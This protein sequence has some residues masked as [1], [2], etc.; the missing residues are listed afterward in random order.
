MTVRK[1]DLPQLKFLAFPMQNAFRPKSNLTLYAQSS[2]RDGISKVTFY[3]SYSDGIKRLIGD[4]ETA[5]NVPE[6]NQCD[7][8]YRKNWTLPSLEDEDQIK[9]IQVWVEAIDKING[10]TE[11]VA[12]G[13][14]KLSNN[15]QPTVSV[16]A[17]PST[18]IEGESVTLSANA[19]D[20]DGSVKSVVFYVGGAPYKTDSTSPYQV[21][22][23]TNSAG[24]YSIYAKVTDNEGLEKKSNNISVKVSPKA[25]PPA[26]SYL[27]LVNSSRVNI[28]GDFEL[29]WDAVGEVTY[30]V[31]KLEVG[32]N[33][34]FVP[35]TT[36]TNNKVPGHE[37]F[38]QRAGDYRYRVFAC[39]SVGCSEKPSPEVSITVVREKPNA[40]K[41]LVANPDKG[42]QLFTGNYKLTWN[43][44]NSSLDGVKPEFYKLQ[45]KT[46]G[47]ESSSKWSTLPTSSLT[48][49]YTASNKQPGNYSY[50]VLACNALGCSTPGE[51]VNVTV[52]PPYLNTAALSCDGGCIRLS[53]SGFDPESSISLK[54]IHSPSTKKSLRFSEA[55]QANS[56]E[57]EFPISK[58]AAIYDALFELGVRITVT[59]PNSAQG[60]ITLYGDRAT[61]IIGETQSTPALSMDGST[62][63]VG[64]ENQLYA[65]DTKNSGAVSWRFAT[66]GVIK[67]SPRVDSIDGTIYVGS[68]DHHFYAVTPHAVEKWRLKTGGEIVSSAILDED[69]TLYFGSMDRNL[70]AV[71]PIE[72]AVKWTYPADGGIAET[73]VL[74]GNDIL[75][76]TTVESNQVH[77]ISRKNRGPGK[78]VWESV[79]DSLLWGEIG[80]WIPEPSMEPEFQSIA[81]LYRGLLQPPLALNRKVLTFWTYQRVA[82]LVSDA[83]IARAFLESDTGRINFSSTLS[84]SDFV[85]TL[86]ERIFPGQGYPDISVGGDT[87]SRAALIGLL[88]GGYARANV[89]LLFTQSLEYTASTNSLLRL[90][91]DYLY[92]QDFSWAVT[93]CN[94]GDEYTRD[95]DGDNLPDWWEILFF[96]HTDYGWEDDPDEDG[97]PNGQAFME[98]ISP[99]QAGCYNGITEKPPAPAEAPQVNLGDLSI[100]ESI[101]ALPGEFRVNEAGAA[102]YSIP[103]SL[104]PGT[105]GVTPE[106]ALAYTSTAGNGIMGKGWT[107]SGLSGISRCRQT[108]GRDGKGEAITWGEGDRFCLDGQRLLL[109]SNGHYGDSGSQYRT[110]VD[111]FALVTAHGG[112]RGKPDFFTVERKDGSI[113]YYGDGNKSQLAFSGYGTL[114]WMLSSFEDS[115]GNEIN[116]IYTQ[117]GGHRIRE[118]Q[119]AYGDSGNAAARVTFEYEDRMDVING[120]SA[121]AFLSTKKRMT[122]IKVLGED[123]TVLRRYELDYLN[124]GYDHLS[125]VERIRECVADS[126]R[127]DT[128]FKWRL[129]AAFLAVN[130][131][132]GVGLS[133]QLDRAN[134]APRPADINGDGLL[135]LIWVET[136][137]DDDERIHDQ[138]FKYVLA[139]GDGFDSEQLVFRYQEDVRV[140]YSWSMIDYNADGRADLVVYVRERGVWVVH[141][142][143]PNPSDGTWSISTSSAAT[144]KE[145]PITKEDT[146]FVDI[147][148]DGLVDAVSATGYQL[149]EKR[150]DATPVSSDF[151]QFGKVNPWTI[152]GLESWGHIDSD[153]ES[154]FQYLDP[155][156][157]GDFNHDGQVD[158]VLV[159]SK[160]WWDRD[161]LNPYPIELSK[162]DL[163]KQHTK[164]YLMQVQGNKLIAKE[165]LLDFMQV[166]GFKGDSRDYAATVLERH[167]TL[168]ESL[169]TVDINS[170]GL[171]DIITREREGNKYRYRINTGD[172]FLDD[173]SLGA[174]PDNVH[175]N[176]FD[177]ELDGDLDMLWRKQD[178][179]L[180]KLVFRRWQARTQSFGEEEHFRT[181]ISSRKGGGDTFV[182]MDGDGQTDYLE[183]HGDH[184]SVYK[185]GDRKVAPNVI[186]KITNG[187]GTE[188]IISYGSTSSSGHFARPG[189]GS[190]MDTYCAKV[191]NGDSGIE[192]WC[193]E[194]KEPSYYSLYNSINED[195]RKFETVDNISYQTLGKT[196]PIL[197]VYTTQFLVTRVQ[198]SAPAAAEYPGSVNSDALVGVSYFYGRAR[199]QAG[200]RGYLGFEKIRTL[201]EQT[202]VA[203]TTTYRQD[204]PFN[205][206]PLRTEQRTASGKL[207]S[208]SGNYWALKGW[209]SEWSEKARSQG[210]SSLGPLQ[211]YVWESVEKAYDLTVNGEVQGNLLKTIT[212]KTEQDLDG[213]TTRVYVVTETPNG[214]SFATETINEYG[215]GERVSFSN[216]DHNFSSYTELGRLTLTRVIHSRKQDGIE[217]LAERKSAFTYYQ[218]GNKAGLLKE[219]ILEP[220]NGGL[221]LV[222]GELRLRTFYDYDH[223]GNKVS[224]EQFADLDKSRLQRWIYDP[225]GRFVDREENSYGQTVSQVLERDQYGQATL[226]EDTAGVRASIGYDVFGR[227]V[228]EYTET[229]AGK[230][231][232]LDH[233]G[234]HCAAGTIYQMV[235]NISG[236]IESITCF[237][238]LTREIRKAS[239]AFDGNWN[240]VD[241]EYDSYGRVKHKSEP[242]RADQS[243][244]WTTQYYDLIGRV[245]GTDLPGIEGIN[246]SG[247]DMLIVYS[248]YTTTATNPKGQ[249]HLETVNALGDKIRVEDNLGNVQEFKY[250]AQGNLRFVIN[251]GDGSRNL[252]TEME[253][254]LLGRKIMM[255]DPDKGQWRY[256]YNAFGEMVKQT[257]AKGQRVENQYDRAG[258][259][260]ERSDY[261][262]ES[263]IV[264]TTLWGYNNGLTRDQ[265]GTPPAALREVVA[266]DSGYIKIHG[267][268]DFGRPSETMTSFAEGDNHYEKSNYD[269]YGRPFQVFDAGGDGS[270]QSSAIQHKYNQ[271]GYLEKV[272]DAEKLNLA[273]AE[274]FYSVLKMDA[275]GNVTEYKTGNGVI[276]YKHFEPATGRLLTQQAQ[277]SGIQGVTDV[278]DLSY[279]WDLLGNLEYREDRSGDKNLREDFTYDGLNR[280]ETAQIQGREALVMRYDDLGNITYKSD[281]GEY[282]Y[283]SQCSKGFGPH[284][285]CETSDGVSYQYDLNGSMES[286]SSGR[287]LKYTTFDKPSEITK[288]GHKTEFLYGPERK[289][290]FRKDT[291]SNGQVSE[292]RYIGNVEKVTRGETTEIK[293]YLPGGALITVKKGERRS[294]YMHKDHLGSLD[295]ITSV[296]G[297][298]ATDTNGNQQVFSFDAWGQR[299]NALDWSVLLD[300]QLTGFATGLTTRGYTGHEMLDQVGLIHMNGRVYDPRLARFLQADPLVQAPDYS[301]SHNRYAYVWNNPL[302]ATD[303]SGYS[304]TLIAA[305][306]LAVMKV[307]AVWVVMAVMAAAGFVDA[308]LQGASFGEAF[309]NGL[310]QGVSAAAF[311]S[312]GQAG[313]GASVTAN[314]V[315]AIK[316]AVLGLL[317]G[318]TS[319]LQGGEFGHGFA[320]SGLG[321][322]A[323]GLFPTDNFV[324]GIIVGG[325][326]SRLSGG[327]FANGAVTAALQIILAK[328]S[329]KAIE[330]ELDRNGHPIPDGPY[331]IAEDTG[332]GLELIDGKLSGEIRFGCNPNEMTICTK[333][334]E[335]MDQMVSENDFLEIK[336]VLVTDKSFEVFIASDPDVGTA[337]YNSGFDSIRFNPSKVKMSGALFKRVFQHE[338]GHVIGLEHKYN[339]TKNFMSY[340]GLGVGDDWRDVEATLSSGQ[341]QKL[342]NAYEPWYQVW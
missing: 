114:N 293:R 309:Q 215:T 271:Y 82:G 233:P 274:E 211:P 225:R 32:V 36:Y 59:N 183:F 77:A 328:G 342:S 262:S 106:L 305:F 234:S 207:L 40:P 316:G 255:S 78:L 53:G 230:V 209:Q 22:W 302:N 38:D 174:F 216:S 92:D 165:K 14:I 286:D 188:T 48:T 29:A 158:L 210:T 128:V 179:E 189:F 6:M 112:S 88:D 284:A 49:N 109:V 287:L 124:T 310:I 131:D 278:Q 20:P 306:A 269:Q 176:W 319:E 132:S 75:Y 172:G 222:D 107:L 47:V 136:D 86:Y 13:I 83:D 146:R 323:N 272:V 134:L 76:F 118:I 27:N 26:P 34:D 276:T 58:Q 45:E 307:K 221:N 85:D 270:W 195:W 330:I 241:T 317:G 8:C 245:I 184:L 37:I 228:L 152:S 214:D 340:Y 170:D 115:A 238:V 121:G 256:R 138:Y 116:Y 266:V 288:D 98:S 125:R 300:K 224:V 251:R 240:Y 90:A 11:L 64:A 220:E 202:G 325:T 312:V 60:G 208:E 79:D 201:D 99:C 329:V 168:K 318:I 149:L 93:T 39:N 18:I 327:K 100:S 94:T 295:V 71:D 197:D 336:N 292:T 217:E 12:P 301:Q 126:C 296:N 237:D 199:L 147:N 31:E 187:L 17:S 142:S 297:E 324:V 337:H 72:G 120:Y 223:F 54:A 282:R 162:P 105:A 229:G 339:V 235:E 7:G 51:I 239:R 231:A 15:Q 4:G 267:Y 333:A 332:Y 260:E 153:D 280:L 341:I 218:T 155:Q 35:D 44:Y 21:Q 261:N 144:L 9:N 67:A 303:P 315:L 314:Q 169:Q 275:R 180:E 33:A 326:I 139:N 69:R 42:A 205:G 97:K 290:Y 46:G 156:A 143:I 191:A 91:F 206:L 50:Q 163:D 41:G 65:L 166:D 298:I 244:Y 108:T 192:S 279:H 173:V 89:A 249:V 212:S 194:Y 243:S 25:P 236:G 268:D 52:L 313:V 294:Q 135:D 57:I 43:P 140:P 283:G 198:S 253:Y 81:R 68:L 66:D 334:V 182:D 289:R 133:R 190:A 320:S 258:R 204:F 154:A 193:L 322:F 63:Y 55:V 80:N 226:I 181:V 96:G 308:L 196:S 331:D 150:P 242:Y 111:S 164:A 123:Y 130:A 104:P 141:K 177:Y 137:W 161:P 304:V 185:A 113:S 254:D 56:T 10:K 61:E 219:E 117:E 24:T 101:G 30:K 103:L 321:A 62:L 2:D 186:E 232:L 171:V 87:Y 277:A 148:G 252:I 281:V 291:A 1:N 95:C 119:Y 157:I 175:L 246:G 127:P 248:G 145:L 102:T 273:T 16:S 178:G 264:E 259:L 28:T 70:Y 311:A 285:L 338:Y 122:E 265:Y 227:K 250:D 74:A 19:S 213:N 247:R 3:Y 23:S 160:V 84:N 151:Y 200:G 110:E 299:R 159:D 129:P 167:G 203:T 263:E 73:P 335:Y 5:T 257:D